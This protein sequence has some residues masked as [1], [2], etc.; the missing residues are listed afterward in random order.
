VTNYT[1][2]LDD[3]F[4]FLNGNG[5]RVIYV[6]E[7]RGMDTVG[8][9][10]LTDVSR[11]GADVARARGAV[12]VDAQRIVDSWP[13]EPMELFR[14]SGIHWSAVGA[15]KLAQAI[16]EAGFCVPS[17]PG[18]LGLDASSDPPGDMRAGAGGPVR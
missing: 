11:A 2:T 12:V 14:E 4:A 13:G 1:R 7:A 16:G 6:I 17:A 3:L 8:L 10:L 18:T 5:V 15:E 9:R